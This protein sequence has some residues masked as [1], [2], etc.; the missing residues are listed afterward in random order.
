LKDNTNAVFR[1]LSVYSSIPRK[2]LSGSFFK[3]SR[4][5]TKYLIDSAVTTPAEQMPCKGQEV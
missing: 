5:L 1:R 2:A 4:R 3:G